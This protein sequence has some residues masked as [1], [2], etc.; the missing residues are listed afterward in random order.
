MGH[1]TCIPLH[2]PTHTSCM[3]SHHPYTHATHQAHMPPLRVPA[4]HICM[5]PTMPSCP[6][7]CLLPMHALTHT[8]PLTFHPT[9]LPA[10]MPPTHTPCPHLPAWLHSPFFPFLF[11]LI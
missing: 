10:H 4:T 8:C 5:P 1:N 6:H 9:C 2:I 11:F 7:A 3:T